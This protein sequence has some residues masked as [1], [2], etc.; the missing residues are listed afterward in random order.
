MQLDELFDGDLI[1]IR[2]IIMPNGEDDSP[3]IETHEI[4]FA[5]LRDQIYNAVEDKLCSQYYMN[6]NNR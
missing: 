6:R 4:A 2:R 1:T 3:T 5:D